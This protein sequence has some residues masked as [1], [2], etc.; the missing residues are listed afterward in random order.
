MSKGT[1]SS[2]I[3]TG[4][5][6]FVIS[7]KRSAR[8]NL[9]PELEGSCGIGDMF[10]RDRF[11]SPMAR[12]ALAK[13]HSEHTI[14]LPM[15]LPPS[16]IAVGACSSKSPSTP[17]SANLMIISNIVN[18]PVLG[19]ISLPPPHI[20]QIGILF[21]VSDFVNSPVLGDLPE[22]PGDKRNF[23]CHSAQRL[24][25]CHFEGAFPLPFRPSANLRE[26]AKRIEKSVLS[27]ASVL[28]SPH[29]IVAR[30]ATRIAGGL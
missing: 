2:V 8:R 4:L 18:Y 27:V 30:G 29:F 20:E 25:P 13:S 12:I 19:G 1:P 16:G 22:G 24:P 23:P 17:D 26:G 6:L 10:L 21:I 15:Q 5:F 14:R 11:S 3:S 28:L 7:T 9:F